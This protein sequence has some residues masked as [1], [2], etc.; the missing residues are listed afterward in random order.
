M[1]RVATL[2]RQTIMAFLTFTAFL[3]PL[4]MNAQI[5]SRSKD[6]VIERPVALPEQA[7]IPGSSFSLYS[8]S[9]GSTYLYVEQKEGTRLTAFDVSDP[10]KIVVISS[11]NLT[12]PAVFDFI[13]PLGERAE[14]IRFRDGKGVAV[15]DLHNLKAP[16]LHMITGLSKSVPYRVARRANPVFFYRSG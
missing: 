7:R 3:V 14:L 11:T 4:V 10:S 16:S 1:E 15:L 9:E 13:R 8:N 6:L 5:Y 2:R 12:V